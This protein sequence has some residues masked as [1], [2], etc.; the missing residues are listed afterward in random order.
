[1]KMIKA[2]LV[3][4][5]LLVIIGLGFIGSG[6]YDIAADT[7]HWPVTEK[8]V[9]TLRERSIA[10]R[11]DAIEVPADLGDAQRLRRG[12]G[13]YDAM[14]A[15][16]HLKPDAD[17][18]EIRKGLYPQPPDLATA[19]PGDPARQFWI[20]KHGIKLTAMPAWAQ[21]GV[22]DATIWDMVALLQKL[23]ALSAQ[24][25]A[26]LVET[27]EG[28]SHAGADRGDSHHGAQTNAHEM[29]GGHHEAPARDHVDA[30]GT[31]PHSHGE[32]PEPE[33]EQEADGHDRPH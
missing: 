13:N 27:S 16:C 5:V 23:P 3:I 19:R 6:V 17:D 30:P 21:G 8:L 20:V 9:E 10:V 25:Y 26:S 7:P 1:M 29:D 24:E 32:A 18:S 15:G 11:A 22:D 31:P 28:H 12:A 33:A 2:L 4:A 14:C